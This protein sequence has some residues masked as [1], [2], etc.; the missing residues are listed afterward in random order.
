MGGF[1]NRFQM[2]GVY[3]GVALRGRQAGMAEE[4]L[5]RAQITPSGQQVGGKGMTERV[6]RRTFR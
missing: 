4:L 5:D 1:V 3:I 6:R 2:G